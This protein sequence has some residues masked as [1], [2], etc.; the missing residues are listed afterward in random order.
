M[1]L[2]MRVIVC[3]PALGGVRP[4]PGVLKGCVM[5]RVRYVVRVIPAAMSLIR[6]MN[7]AAEAAAAVIN[8]MSPVTPPIAATVC[9]AMVKSFVFSMHVHLLL[10]D[11]VYQPSPAMKVT[12]NATVLW[13]VTVMTGSFVPAW[14]AVRVISVCRAEIPVPN[15]T[16]FAM[17][18]KINATIFR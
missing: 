6:M 9:S 1:K 7:V 13:M 15:R 8:W 17:S 11:P 18:S 2:M 10:M 14:K 5:S 16:L 12:M 4:V 3:I